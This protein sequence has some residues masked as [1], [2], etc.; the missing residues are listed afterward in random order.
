MAWFL[1]RLAEPYPAQA[2]P[3]MTA[4]ANIGPIA[5]TVDA[6]SWSVASATLCRLALRDLLWHCFRSAYEEGVYNGCNQVNPDLDHNVQVC[7]MLR[8][9]VYC[10]SRGSCPQVVRDLMMLASCS[11]LVTALTHNWATT[12]SFATLGTMCSPAVSCLLSP[13]CIQL[14]VPSWV[15]RSVNWGEKGYIRVFRG[16]AANPSCGT[17]LHPSDGSGCNNGPAT[18]TVCGTCGILYDN[19]YPVI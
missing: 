8:R 10:P 12:G 3:F 16:N 9:A 5:I 19:V 6:S 15:A 1:A 13:G 14:F 7:S 2:V 18:V 11:V 17:D 4:L